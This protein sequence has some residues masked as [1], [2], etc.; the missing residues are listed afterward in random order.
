ML[1][2]ELRLLFAELFLILVIQVL[3]SLDIIF[4]HNFKENCPKYGYQHH[5]ISRS[6]PFSLGQ[7]SFTVVPTLTAFRNKYGPITPPDHNAH[8]IVFQ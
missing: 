2:I 7:I 8:Q 3:V 5:N 1:E 6:I 4:L